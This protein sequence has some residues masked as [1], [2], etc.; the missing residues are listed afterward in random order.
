VKASSSANWIL[1]I[2]PIDIDN[3][4]RIDETADALGRDYIR[5]LITLPLKNKLA[6]RELLD[7]TSVSCRRRNLREPPSSYIGSPSAEKIV[8]RQCCKS[9]STSRP[10]IKI[11]FLFRWMAVSPPADAECF[12][13]IPLLGDAV[14]QNSCC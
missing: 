7:E 14:R 8:E 12:E 11:T 1:L 4:L 2:E 10:A 13:K 5:N 6:V 9:T 3:S